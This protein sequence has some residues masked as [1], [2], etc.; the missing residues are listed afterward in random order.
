[1]CDM[2]GIDV[3]AEVASSV[4]RR[5]CLA[6]VRADG[7]AQ[8]SRSV[9]NYSPAAANPRNNHKATVKQRRN[10]ASMKLNVKNIRYLTPD[11]WRVLTA[12]CPAMP[13]FVT[14]GGL[15]LMKTRAGRDG[16]P[17]P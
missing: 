17:Q 6:L 16:E 10:T 14:V 7:R 8:T 3:D 9:Q 4:H 12:V 2:G 1:M 5:R 11:D 15:T 13:R